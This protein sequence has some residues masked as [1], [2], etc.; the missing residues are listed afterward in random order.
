M[1]KRKN[2]YCPSSDDRQST[3]QSHREEDAEWIICRDNDGRVIEPSPVL[4]R[5][6]EQQRRWFR[7]KFGRDPGP[8]D[9]VFFDPDADTPQRLDG[10]LISD[11]AAEAAR[12]AGIPGAVIYAMR[13]TGLVIVPGLNDHRF[14]REEFTQWLTAAH[15]F[16]DVH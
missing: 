13:K 3:R 15:E 14:T 11:A 4:A 16:E 10:R 9:P 2:P 12:Q 5:A 1:V 7:Q 8:G 6:L